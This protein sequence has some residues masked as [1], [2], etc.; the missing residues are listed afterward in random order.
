MIFKIVFNSKFD[1]F[2][3]SIVFIVSGSNQPEEKA[4]IVHYFTGTCELSP[5][6]KFIWLKIEDFCDNDSSLVTNSD[7]WL[8]MNAYYI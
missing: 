3:A 5:G 7:S 2:C 6:N 4:T 8:V 1:Q